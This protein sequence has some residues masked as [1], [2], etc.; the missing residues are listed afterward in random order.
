MEPGPQECIPEVTAKGNW[1]VLQ[2]LNAKGLPAMDTTSLSDPYVQVTV[3][4]NHRPQCVS[5]SFP[6]ILNSENPVWNSSRFLNA[7]LHIQDGARPSDELFIIIY[8]FDSAL[9]SACCG[10][11]VI[12]WCRLKVSEIEKSRG[13]MITKPIKLSR[14]ASRNLEATMLASPGTL[15]GTHQ[16]RRHST[17]TLKT[18]VSIASQMS[19]SG[20]VSEVNEQMSLEQP[21]IVPTESENTTNSFVEKVL[22]FQKS[23]KKNKGVVRKEINITFRC[24]PRQ[25][26]MK[27]PRIKWLFFIR[28]GESLWNVAEEKLLR[29]QPTSVLFTKSDHHISVD[30]IKQANALNNQVKLLN[31]LTFHA[32]GMNDDIAGIRDKVFKENAE[33]YGKFLSGDRIYSSPLSRAL[34]TALIALRE[35][36]MSKARGIYLRSELREVK[37]TFGADSRSRSQG[38]VIAAR[39][40]DFVAEAMDHEKTVRGKTLAKLQTQQQ[41]T[42]LESLAMNPQLL[43]L[44]EDDLDEIVEHARECAIDVGNTAHEWWNEVKESAGELKIRIKELLCSLKLSGEENVILV[45]HSLLIRSI[46]REFLEPEFKKEYSKKKPNLATHKMP[47]CGVVALRANFNLHIENCIDRVELLFGTGRPQ[48]DMKDGKTQRA[49]SHE[50]EHRDSLESDLSRTY[51]SDSLPTLDMSS[52]EDDGIP[53]AASKSG[54]RGVHF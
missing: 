9:K 19:V 45:S 8:D 33:L 26:F 53:A 7:P 12:G 1:T 21:C 2:L 18:T 22:Q 30:G 48:A 38:T 15:E 39:A 17:K 10:N 52:D 47:N 32:S 23:W 54:M 41:A 5:R 20:L 24:V 44:T 29:F 14:L 46:I 40:R 16:D 27:W 50:V 42:T 35:H 28:H 37:N 6:Y 49:K 31:D 13:F 11:D 36:P 51:S 4:R 3:L 43:D 25:V 34:Q